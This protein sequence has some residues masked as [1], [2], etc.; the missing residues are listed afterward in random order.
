[1]ITTRG[2][3]CGK[4]PALLLTLCL[5]ASLMGSGNHASQPQTGPDIDIKHLQFADLATKLGTMPPGPGRDYFAGVLANANN[6]IAESID[7]LTRALPS[8]REPRPDRAAVALQTLADDYTKIFKYADAAR[9]ANDLLRNFAGQLTPEQVKGANDDMGIME[10]LRDAPAQT[11]AWHGTVKLKT[12]RNPIN[13]LNATLTVNGVQAQWLLDTGANLSLVSKGF[14]KQLGLKLLPGTA[15]TRAGLTGIKNPLHVA[16]L[17]TLQIGGAT[18]QNVVIMVLEDSSLRI[19]LGK[20]A[21][22]INGI[23]GYPVFQALGSIS[24]LHDGEFVAEPAARSAASGAPLFMKGLTPIVMCT[25]EGRQLPFSFDT[26]ASGTDLYVRYYREF[27]HES[28][29][30]KKGTEKDGGAGGV[31]KR[32]VFFQPEVKLGVGDKTVMLK[33]VSIYTTGT[34]TDTD[35]LYGNLGQDVP[36]NFDSFTLDFNNMSFRLGEPLTNSKSRDSGTINSPA[37]KP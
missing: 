5:Q 33:K 26:G 24:F 20:E 16:I 30:W 17:P 12:E 36:A 37:V 8:L 35:Q 18:L 3:R 6:H 15:Y 1:M 11:I 4:L 31:I 32:K 2:C 9:T 25:I 13:S 29:D 28:H 34:G 7:L 19:G 22:Q 21:Y 14:A 27:N 23:I 10:I